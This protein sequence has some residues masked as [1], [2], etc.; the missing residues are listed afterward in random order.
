MLPI[1]LENEFSR[2][3]ERTQSMVEVTICVWVGQIHPALAAL[4]FVNSR[5][6]LMVCST[7]FCNHAK[8]GSLR[9]GISTT[10]ARFRDDDMRAEGQ[11]TR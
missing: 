3:G 7:G 9:H 5:T 6:K 1:L 4:A 2:R 10:C 8:K 11:D